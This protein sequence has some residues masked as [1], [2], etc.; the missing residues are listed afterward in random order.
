MKPRGR[1]AA[2]AAARAIDH[3]ASADIAEPA[4]SGAPLHGAGTW[5]ALIVAAAC[6]VV[7]SSYVLYDTDLWQLLAVGRSTWAHHGAPRLD[8]W[9]W[10]NFGTPV[11]VSSWAFRAVIWPLWSS[12]GVV[13]LTLWRWALTLGAF[14]FAYATARTLGAQGLSAIVVMVAY[15]LAYRLRTDIRPEALAAVLLAAELWILERA[16]RANGVDAKGAMLPAIVAI[17]WLWAN[18][19]ISWYLGLALL[20]IHGIDAWLSGAAARARTL[21]GVGVAGVIAMVINPYGVEAL[22]R[23]FRFVFEWR[24]DPMFASI[25]ELASVPLASPVGLGLLVWPLLVVGRAAGLWPWRGRRLD[26]VEALTC[27]LFT[28]IGLASLRF[29]AASALVAAPYVARDVEE[30]VRA[31]RARAPRLPHGA[32]A[33]LAAAACVALGL[34]EWLRTDLPLGLRI[35]PRTYPERACD[36]LARHRVRGRGFNHFHLSG[37]LAYRFEGDPGRR[38]FMSTQPELS[39]PEQRRLY[40]DGL[41]SQ[42]G[43][44]ALEDRF[45]FDWLLLDPTPGPGDSLLDVLD[46]EPRWALVF[47]DDAGELLVRRDGPLAAVADSFAYRLLP[48]GPLAR[49]RLG[50][51]CERDPVLRAR[52]EA[53][54]DRMIASSSLDAGA[55][56][57]RGWFALMDGDRERARRHLERALALEPGL[58]GVRE[59]L[60]TLGAR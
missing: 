22:V 44:H 53:E 16:R 14:G 37:Y 25:A 49:Y 38:P 17:L 51:S 36:F 29:V 41:Q 45:R 43:W 24:G 4:G 11:F 27:A 57:L 30:I 52:A 9:T 3:V 42:E 56:H 8:L 32:R 50:V 6:L 12:G 13:A 58:P 2:R 55:S 46:R 48:A 40:V 18:V 33:A 21:S 35:D 20:G 5:L 23:P 47:A 34:P 19:H 26:R 31:R 54:L 60:R 10:P 1:R 39:S 7:S 15:S 59:M 28:F